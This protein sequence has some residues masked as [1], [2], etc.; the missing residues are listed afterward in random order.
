MEVW[1]MIMG[2]TFGA[3]LLAVV[4]PVIDVALSVYIGVRGIYE[5]KKRKKHVE[6]V[7][8]CGTIL[9]KEEE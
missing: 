4:W 6:K 8:K 5:G 9:Y 7:L 2:L 3:F 1:S